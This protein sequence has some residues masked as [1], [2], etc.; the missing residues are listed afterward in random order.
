[1]Q[2]QFFTVAKLQNL[3]HLVGRQVVPKNACILA[4]SQ[5]SILEVRIKRLL[6]P[7][8]RGVSSINHIDICK[9]GIKLTNQMSR[10]LNYSTF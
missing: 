8:T 5:P 3:T 10:S 1:M 4:S 9:E 2:I 7:V 6:V